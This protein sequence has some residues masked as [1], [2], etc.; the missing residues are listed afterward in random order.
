MIHVGFDVGGTNIK[1]GLV[2][3]D[4]R[5]ITKRNVPFPRGS[6]EKAAQVMENLA[7]EMLAE[8]GLGR[9]DIKSLGIA[10]PGNIDTEGSLV[11][12]AYNLD[13]HNV[14]MKGEMSGRFPGVPVALGNDANL[15]ALAELYAGAFRGYKTAVL[16]TLGTGV[17]GGVILGGR[18]FNGGKEHGVELG[19]MCLLHD[20][21]QCTC[22]NRGCVETVCAATWLTKQGRDVVLAGRESLIARKVRNEEGR[23]NAKTVLDCAREG[24]G[25]ALEIF[26]QYIEYLSSAIVSLVALLDPEIIALGGGV[27]LAG[28][29]LFEPLREKVWKKS[30]FKYKHRIVPAEMG[31]DAG[32]IGA[33]ML[34][35]DRC[36]NSK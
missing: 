15:A 8:Q 21:P 9:R 20:G 16:M 11:I 27:S 31:N 23:V 6:Y 18:M 12:D 36:G 24:D 26:E 34:H 13:F 17:G 10:I 22:G 14:P 5:I 25:A 4:A 2:D 35:E 3:G 1:A 19:H 28:D 30:F 7:W 32:I 29:F 33:A